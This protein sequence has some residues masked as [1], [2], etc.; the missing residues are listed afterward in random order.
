MVDV[1][2]WLG[3]LARHLATILVAVTLVWTIARPHAQE[4]V[5]QSVEQRIGTIEN[6]LKQLER[7]QTAARLAASRMEAD[8][9]VVKELQK[10]TR[11]DVKDVLRVLRDVHRDLE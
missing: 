8:V 11:E 4:F 3:I 9:D 10:E 1:R 6:Q 7:Q 5:R 2:S